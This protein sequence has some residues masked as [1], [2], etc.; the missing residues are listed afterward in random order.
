[1]AALNEF[2]VASEVPKCLLIDNPY[3]VPVNWDTKDFQDAYN[4]YIKRFEDKATQH[5][6]GL[7]MLT[8]RSNEVVTKTR[9]PTSWGQGI[10]ETATCAP[11]TQTRTN[12]RTHTHTHTHTI[13]IY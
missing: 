9:C 10:G 2:T 3:P 11:Q 1:M 13:Y 6:Q 5:A 7:T 4:R 12:I 8:L